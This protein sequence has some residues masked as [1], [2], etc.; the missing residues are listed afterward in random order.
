MSQFRVVVL[1]LVVHLEV[2]VPR[3]RVNKLS[4]SQA[5]TQLALANKVTQY[6]FSSTPLLHAYVTLLNSATVK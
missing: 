5:Q 1:L 3:P 2:L 4:L 6:I